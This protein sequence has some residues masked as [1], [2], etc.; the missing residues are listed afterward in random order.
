VLWIRR[1]DPYR[2][3]PFERQAYGETEIG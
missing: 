3:N 1:R 2:E